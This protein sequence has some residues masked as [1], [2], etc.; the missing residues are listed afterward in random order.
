MLGSL[1]GGIASGILGLVGGQM[2]NDAQANQ[3]AQANNFSAAQTAAQ[4]D[5]QREMWTHARDYNTTMAIQQADWANRS[6]DKGI[7]FA[8]Q[9]FDRAEN[10]QNTAYQRA[11]SDMRAAG[12]NPMLA[13]QQGSAG[14][15]AP[16]GGPAASFS[17]PSMGVPGGASA[18]G[19]Q[20]Q[21]ENV[22]GPAVG[23]AL[24]A[25]N[26]VQGVQNLAAQLDKTKADTE[27][28]RANTRNVDTNTGLQV[29]QTVTETGRPD[30]VAAEVGRARAQTAQSNA[31]TALANAQTGLVG[32]QTATERERP[33]GV[34]AEAHRD[35]L[36]GNLSRIE[37]HL[38]RTYGTGRIGQ[39]V[40][41]IS[42]IINSIR[43]ALR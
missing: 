8:Q 21:M 12:L 5:F 24:Q 2:R 6:Q 10:M 17:A 13:Y 40:G 32:A 16:I 25:A 28:T 3:A 36:Q 20:A 14:S 30:L 35:W 22:L 34:R 42:Q 11:M 9:T 37:E 33:E 26:A 29:A 38:R 31:S 41:G 19:Q 4:M 43:E 7:A 15:T 39:E 18:S 23:S 1:L 27:L